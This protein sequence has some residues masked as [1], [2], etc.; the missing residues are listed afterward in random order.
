M[1][2]ILNPKYAWDSNFVVYPGS[3]NPLHYGHIAVAKR[4]SMMFEK[5]VMFEVSK[6]RCDKKELS[7]S[8]ILYI[9]Q[10]FDAYKGEDWF[11]GV[12]FTSDPYFVQKFSLFPKQ[13]FIVG[14]DTM[15]RMCD[16]KY[17]SSQDMYSLM[18]QKIM[19]Q[20][21][22]F[23]I[24]PRKDVVLNPIPQEIKHLCTLVSLTE[25]P[26][27]GIS[28]TKIRESLEILKSTEKEPV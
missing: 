24:F 26:D 1:Y 19:L 23:L 14:S 4:S 3:F 8:E 6:I 22:Q 10:S 7:E 9:Y 12:C 15:N 21:R 16:P 17:H 11:Y 5:P 13:D 27:D 2:A 28:S 20:K 25:H 18:I